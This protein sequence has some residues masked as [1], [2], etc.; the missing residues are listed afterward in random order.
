MAQRKTVPADPAVTSDGALAPAHRQFQQNLA[1]PISD[2]AEL[3]NLDSATTYTADELRDKV[4]E[5]MS[6]LGAKDA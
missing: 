5:L 3:T 4:I 2:V 6:A 1:K